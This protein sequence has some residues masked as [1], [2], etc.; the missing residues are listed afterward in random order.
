MRTTGAQGLKLIKHFEGFY[1]T[2]YLDPV[3]IPTI[4]YGHLVKDGLPF[5]E[6][7]NEDQALEL[8]K[9]DL[10]IAEK[11]VNRLVQVPLMQNQFDALVSFTFNL[12]AGALQRSTLRRK[13]NAQEHDQVGPEF[14]RWVWAS[15]R[16]LPGLIKRRQAEAEL[17]HKTQHFD[18]A[19][20]Y[21]SGRWRS[22]V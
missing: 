9:G 5:Q 14:T 8:L 16:K 19:S 7:I 2:T 4:G 6:P 12:G 1:P 11:A 10:D 20:V 13:V 17:Y 22:L 18:S 3:G 21:T 15:G